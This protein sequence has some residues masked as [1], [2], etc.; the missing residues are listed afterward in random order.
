MQICLRNPRV[1]PYASVQSIT[2]TTDTSQKLDATGPPIVDPSMY[3]SLAE[4]LQYRTFTRL[5]LRLRCSRYA[6]L[7]MIL[8]SLIF[9]LWSVFCATYKWLSIMV[10]SF[11]CHPPPISLLTLT[12]IGVGVSFLVVRPR[13]IVCFLVIILSL[14]Y[15]NYKGSYLGLV[16][17]LSIEAL[18]TS[19]LRLIGFVIYFV[20]FDVR[21]PKLLLCIV[22]TSAMS[23]WLR[24]WFSTNTPSTSRLIY[25]LCEIRL[26]AT[27]FE[28]FMCLRPINTPISSQ[29]VFGHSSST[30]SRPVWMSKILFP[31]QLW[32]DVSRYTIMYSYLY[33]SILAKPIRYLDY[34]VFDPCPN[35][36]YCH[37]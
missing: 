35:Y 11:M 13:V 5:I 16:L 26:L 19:W 27:L 37:V 21:P 3:R 31:F 6:S 7:C 12:S 9:M 15:P 24:T 20:S 10:F 17:K 8:G 14:G 4:A 23:T 32:G 22:T 33:Y 30:N 25:V 34:H 1:C 2:H 18:Q 28:F 36:I 29:K